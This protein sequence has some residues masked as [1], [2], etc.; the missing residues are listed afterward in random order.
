ML[1]RRVQEKPHEQHPSPLL[2]SRA[3]QIS[4]QPIPWTKKQLFKQHWRNTIWH[5][6]LP[7]EALHRWGLLV[8]AMAFA[9]PLKLHAS[10]CFDDAKP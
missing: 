10:L 4:P 1:E 3:K 8:F 6:G 9:L 5:A 7:R 2:R